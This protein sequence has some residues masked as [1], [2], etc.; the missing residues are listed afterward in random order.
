GDGQEAAK[1][2]ISESIT[3][4]K[5]L[6]EITRTA[7]AMSELAICYRRAGAHDE[8]RVIY[9][10]ALSILADRNS[11]LKAKILLRL[12]VAE[13]YSG[14]NNDA[15]RIL[16]DTTSFFESSTNQILKGKFHN[17]LALVLRKLGTTER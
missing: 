2:L 12:V 17:E 10:E 6:G 8:A 9:T 4:F 1:D 15:L 3:R 16:T 5:D 14:R 7:D 13:S 11:E